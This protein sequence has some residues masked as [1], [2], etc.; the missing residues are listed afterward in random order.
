MLINTVIQRETDRNA[1]MNREYEALIADLPKGTLICRRNA[2]YYLKYRE[3]G[4]V[5]EK[6]IGKDEN[7]VS[8][9]KH[10]LELRRH[11][12]EMLSA[13]K[14]EQKKINK[15]LEKMI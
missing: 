3:N 5:C 4:K 15:I 12:T 13:L 8:D 2:Y 9:V 1:Q 7:A 14:E 6:Y 11:Y 10:K